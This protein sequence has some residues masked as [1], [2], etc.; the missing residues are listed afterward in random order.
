LFPR[1]EKTKRK[2]N[3]LFYSRVIN[4]WIGP[5]KKKITHLSL[6]L[7]LLSSRLPSSS[8]FDS[9]DDEGERSMG[10][11]PSF[12]KKKTQHFIYP[13]E[14]EGKVNIDGDSTGI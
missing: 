12:L 3:K 8:S 4:S 10:R 11:P 13:H 9:K 7:Q 2:E 1:N 5:P 14:R 6:S